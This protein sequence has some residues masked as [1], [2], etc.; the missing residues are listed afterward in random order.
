MA[1]SENS[2]PLNDQLSK[3]IDERGAFDVFQF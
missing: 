3:L 2:L 1:T